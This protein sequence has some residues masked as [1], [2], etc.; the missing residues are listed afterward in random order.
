MFIFDNLMDLDDKNLGALMRMVDSAI[1]TLALKGA[2]EPLVDRMF[3]RMSARAAQ[4]I[5]DEMEERGMVKRVEVDE[6]Q[7]AIIAIARQMANDGTI[8][9]AGAGEDYV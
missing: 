7:R 2:A 3:G 4:T 9:L 6:A 1:L 8:M 5:R